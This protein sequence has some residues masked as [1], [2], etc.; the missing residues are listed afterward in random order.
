MTMVT[1]A[2]EGP[3][4]PFE[5]LAAM[6]DR[7]RGTTRKLEKMAL[8][9]NY[10]ATLGDND[11]AIAARYIAGQVFP[12]HDMRVLQVGGAAIVQMLVTLSGRTREEIAPLS[13]RLGELGEVAREVLPGHLPEESA[14]TLTAVEVAVEELA[15][16]P[17]TKAKTT[18]LT[19]LVRRA[20]PLEAAYLVKLVSGDLRIGLKQGLVED[21]LARG[22]GRP[23]AAVSRAAMLLGDLGEVAVLARAG[24]L[25]RAEL[26][27]FHPLGAMLATPA[28]SPEEAL[29]NLPE[30]WALV[31]DKFDGIRAQVHRDGDRL[32]IY[33]RTLDEITHRF[34]ELH[35]PLLALPAPF[36]LDGEIIGERE[37]R[38]LSFTQFQQRLGRKAVTEAMLQD[39]PAVLI[40]FDLLYRDGDLLFARPLTERRI[41]LATLLQG[42]DIS[43]AG[44]Q[45][46]EREFDSATGSALPSLIEKA[47]TLWAGGGPGRIV[48][49]SRAQR[50]TMPEEIETL[51]AAARARGNEGLMVKLPHSAYTPGRRGAEW[52]KVKR[53]LASL[54]VVVTAVEWGHGKRRHV[55]SDYTFAVRA[56]ESDPTLLNIGKA[57]SG[58]T[59]AE[60]ATL[61]QWFLAHTHQ[62]YGR[63]RSVEPTII[64]EITFDAV[65]ESK[66]HKS[67]YA[68]RFPRILRVRDDKPLDEIDTL[69]SVRAL[70][71]Q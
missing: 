43:L 22:F 48:R 28:A 6:A 56:S 39:I 27:L 35:A 57:Y 52:R 62:D 71:E 12:Q 51:F 47:D 15:V 54:D 26:R 14:L 8:L 41:L 67:G 9:A 2:Q 19:N 21:A 31:E 69:A 4:V 65:Q 37:G 61:T 3:S 40:A 18:L 11:L 1:F 46:A 53:A 23:L 32:A 13:V 42:G 70:A 68:L 44:E 24:T 5:T 34:P 45:G 55:L 30:E 38:A 64:L 16:T 17:G 66:R 59:D 58:L 63:G 36:I 25:D 29:A 50:V 10:F 20:T 60:I 49:L 33:S 7:V